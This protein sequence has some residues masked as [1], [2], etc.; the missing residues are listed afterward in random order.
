MIKGVEESAVRFPST[1]WRRKCD[2]K[3]ITWR[4]RLDFSIGG[5]TRHCTLTVLPFV[6]TVDPGNADVCMAQAEWGVYFDRSIAV[7]NSNC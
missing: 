2:Q 3:P 7:P 1:R 5:P 4:M 6:V